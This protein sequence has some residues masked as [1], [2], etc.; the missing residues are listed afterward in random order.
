MVGANS[1]RD[2]T[3]NR[4]GS[5]EAKTRNDEDQERREAIESYEGEDLH[6]NLARAQTPAIS[7]MQRRYKV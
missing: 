4:L 7:N 3:E 2:A 6:I 1:T 5:N